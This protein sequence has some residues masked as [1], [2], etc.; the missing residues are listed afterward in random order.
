MFTHTHTYTH[1][2]ARIYSEYAIYVY[3]DSFKYTYLMFYINSSALQNIV[4]SHSV[5]VV[6]SFYQSQIMVLRGTWNT[7][8]LFHRGVDFSNSLR[9]RETFILYEKVRP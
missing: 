3:F 2:H 4:F 8:L 7:S 9:E 6:N 1:T 5:S